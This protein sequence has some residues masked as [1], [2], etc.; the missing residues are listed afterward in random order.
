MDQHYLTNRYCGSTFTLLC[1]ILYFRIS[2]GRRVLGRAAGAVRTTSPSTRPTTNPTPCTSCQIGRSGGWPSGYKCCNPLQQAAGS[3]G[4]A[5]SGDDTTDYTSQPHHRE[6]R[7]P[8]RFKRESTELFYCRVILLS[9][10]IL[11][12]MTKRKQRRYI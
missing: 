9:G 7:L 11:Q 5:E 2:V 10:E 1:F 4:S 12:Y 8:L 6:P 3:P